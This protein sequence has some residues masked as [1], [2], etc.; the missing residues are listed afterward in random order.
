[1]ENIL[2]Y[3]LYFVENITKLILSYLYFL[4]LF[5]FILFARDFIY[6]FIYLDKLFETSK[7]K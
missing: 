4:I 7:R 1:M 2:Y 5:H 3:S 6:L